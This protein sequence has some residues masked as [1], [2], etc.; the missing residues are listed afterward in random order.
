MLRVVLTD[1]VARPKDDNGHIGLPDP[2]RSSQYVSAVEREEELCLSFH[3]CCQDVNILGVNTTTVLVEGFPGGYR[4]KLP[5]HLHQQ[6]VEPPEALLRESSQG[7][8]GL[9]QDDESGLRS[10]ATGPASLK[11]EGRAP[12]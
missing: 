11:E 12:F 6:P 4:K 7:M 1:K 9:K 3:C 2:L 8:E 10:E 5:V